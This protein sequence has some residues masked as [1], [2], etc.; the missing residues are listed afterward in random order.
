MKY[1]HF[2]IV[3]V[4]VLC[5]CGCGKDAELPIQGLVERLAPEYSDQ[6][7]FKIED[8]NS[9]NDCFTL[10][11]IKT[12]KIL[13]TGNSCLS[14]S[15]GLNHYLK[16]FCKTSISWF[17][18]DPIE[19]PD[20]LPEVP[21]KIF[22]EAI[23]EKRFFLNY[24]TFGYTMPWWDWSDW[25]RLID[26]MALNGI[27]M[28]LSITGQEAIWYKVWSKLGLT[29]K[30][31]RHYF[32]GP[33]HL[34]WHRMS[35]LDHWSG[36]LPQSWIDHQLELQKKIVKRERELGMTPILPAFSGHVPASL[37][38]VFPEATI[39]K[40]GFWGGF[41]DSYRSHFLDPLDPL[42]PRIQE[43]FLKEQTLQFGTDHIYG[44]DPF[45]EVEP[46]S[47]EPEYLATVSNS[48]YKSMKKVD[49]KAQ[50][51]QMSWIFYFDRKHWTNER[52]DAMLNAVPK[53]K[54]IL[55]DY[56]CENTEVWKMTN[57]FF[58]QPFI[59]CY[60]GNFGGNT[61]LAG[62]LEEIDKR[63]TETYHNGGANFSG[64]GSTLEALDVN[65][66]MYEFVFE[67]VWNPQ[68]VDL[69]SWIHSWSDRRCG[70]DDPNNRKAWEILL[71]EVYKYPAHL[72]QATLTNARPTLLG[73][74]N[75]TTNPEIQYSNK[76]LF[77]AW[78]IMLKTKPIRKDA[79]NFD[80]VNLG[81]Q[82]LGNHFLK[83]RDKFTEAYT[84]DK[85]DLLKS[86]ANSMIELL[87]DMDEL[88]STH[89]SFLLE[90][91]L[92]DARSF[93][94]DIE[95]S[96]Y[97]QMNARNIITTWGGQTQ[98]LN[99]YGNRA[100]A[101]LLAN[102]YKPRWEMFL[103]EVISAKVNSYEFNEDEFFQNVTKFEIEWVHESVL[104]HKVSELSSVEISQ[105][106]VEKYRNQIVL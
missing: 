27:N 104:H 82:V 102:Y 93:G 52:I 29:D 96:E 20:I 31:I 48:I 15:V 75:W 8:H 73:S 91:W 68:A 59:W 36:P 62:N 106:L 23:V 42:F 26:W 9:D 88:L 95:E 97:Y 70:S 92:H 16:Y 44:V 10:E 13:I 49:P 103:S 80:I 38:V 19:L 22:K 55:L 4:T 34:P 83:L 58:Q 54:M 81:R 78:D 90:N 76:D 72:G 60:L 41:N 67:K 1:Y 14:M 71:Q 35:N 99:D 51:L 5:I 39:S 94:I 7:I 11:T 24:C 18:E 37:K 84:N 28:P 85:I 32:T 2:Y 33:A 3:L 89:H 69:R 63:I 40:L 66:L 86:L 105:L 30:Q 21:E 57:S 64:I 25:E 74:G 50:W 77:K 53:N 46:P 47:W 6:F 61:M 45:N 87:D 12:G 101:G 43:L 100:W 79:Y 56:F 17:K 65:P 98:S